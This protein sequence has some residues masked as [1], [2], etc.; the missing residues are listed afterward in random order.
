MAKDEHTQLWKLI[1][2]AKFAMLTH[3]HGDGHLH[4]QPLTTQNKEADQQST[5]YFFVARDGD[6]VRHL[7]SD[8]NVNV[9]YANLDDDDY[10]SISG[11]AAVSEDSAKKTELF[12]PLVKAWF[13]GGVDDPNLALLE[14]RI[15][16]AEYWKAKDSKVVQLIKMAAAAVT[17]KPPADMAEHRKL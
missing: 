9:S 5:L 3:R 10:V 4:S 13:P 14:V 12:N 16:A 11:V 2:S 17:G 15:Q 7:S 6:I 8:P 1:R